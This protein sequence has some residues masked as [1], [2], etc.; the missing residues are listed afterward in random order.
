M[1]VKF[2]NFVPDKLVSM[3][4]FS[5]KHKLYA[6]KIKKKKKQVLFAISNLSL[7]LLL[8]FQKNQHNCLKTIKNLFDFGYQNFIEF[9]KQ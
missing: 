5:R 7:L 6:I 1:A 9:L 4:G 8:W 3:C 2:K